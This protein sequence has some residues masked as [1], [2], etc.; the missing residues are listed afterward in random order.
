MPEIPVFPTDS[1][2]PA[3]PVTALEGAWLC[4]VRVT[5]LAVLALAAGFGSYLSVFLVGLGE[6]L[7]FF[8]KTGG[9]VPTPDEVLEQ[10][11]KLEGK[12]K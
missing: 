8:G 12:K 6:K 9:V 5:E 7:H 10:L 1:L 11:R 2:D 3:L 4:F